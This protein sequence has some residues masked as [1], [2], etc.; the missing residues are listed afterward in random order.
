MEVHRDPS[1][2]ITCPA[3]TA[4]RE[5]KPTDARASARAASDASTPVAPPAHG[6]FTE[7]L[8]SVPKNIQS[9]SI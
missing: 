8:P 3:R 7:D 2:G 1:T 4:A 9:A 5:S 6:L